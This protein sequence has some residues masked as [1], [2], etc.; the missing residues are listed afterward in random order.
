M[1]HVGNRKKMVY[2]LKAYGVYSGVYLFSWILYSLVVG[3]IKFSLYIL[4]V[5][6][7]LNNNTDYFAPTFGDYSGIPQMKFTLTYENYCGI[8]IL[9]FLTT[10]SYTL[11][12]AIAIPHN[13][14]GIKLLTPVI[15]MGIYG[16]LLP[17]FITQ[18]AQRFYLISPTGWLIHITSYKSLFIPLSIFKTTSV[19]VNIFLCQFFVPF[20]SA[21]LL[22]LLK[23]YRF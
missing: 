14:I 15:L 4:C 3:T 18:N 11:F 21:I 10:Y 7:F 5:Y 12:A 9:A 20:C 2:F 19:Y 16:I 23:I 17:Y 22:E 6:L 13:Q 8:N 1:L